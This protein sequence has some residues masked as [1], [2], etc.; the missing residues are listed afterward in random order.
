MIKVFE[1]ISNI[2]AFSTTHDKRLK[3]MKFIIRS[4]FKNI[5]EHMYNQ[6]RS[7]NDLDN[8]LKQELTK[9][10]CLINNTLCMKMTKEQFELHISDPE[11]K[12][13]LPG[14][15]KL[16]CCNGLKTANYKIWFNARTNALNV[17]KK[18][19]D[20]QMLKFLSCSDDPQTIFTY[21][22]FDLPKL[23]TMIIKDKIIDFKTGDKERVY[24]LTADFFLST[25]AIQIS[26]IAT[27]IVIINNVYSKNEL[28][29]INKFAESMTQLDSQREIE[30]KITTRLLEIENQIKFYQIM[31]PPSQLNILP[32]KCPTTIP[33][34]TRPITSTT[35]K[36]GR[37][38]QNTDNICKFFFCG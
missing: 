5:E 11:T 31:F 4:L 13:L 38:F 34:T 9:W 15:K 10:G 30:R 33:P 24:A 18:K 12:K 32:T 37:K 14:W 35:M 28:D 2:F 22:Q 23:E 19:S 3:P 26:T 6:T 21:L 1:H 17:Y 8:Y 20:Y 29:M 16:I 27:L 7:N 25:F 36:Y